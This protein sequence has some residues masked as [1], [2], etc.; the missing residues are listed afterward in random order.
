MKQNP[1]SPVPGIG[2]TYPSCLC[3]VSTSTSRPLPVCPMGFDNNPRT[4]A[5]EAE[6]EEVTT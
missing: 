1:W 3:I 4:V 5:N 6:Y 2:C